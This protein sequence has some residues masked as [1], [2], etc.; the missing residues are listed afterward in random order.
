MKKLFLLGLCA[1]LSLATWASTPPSTPE[2]PF[3][4]D[5]PSIDQ[6]FEGMTALEQWVETCETTYSDL[7]AENNALLQNVKN[8]HQDISA[9]LLGAGGEMDS[10]LKVILIVLGALAV[11]TLGCCLAI[12]IWGS[13]SYY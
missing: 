10:A 5:L 8:D 6:A 11:I 3:Q 2:N 7:A 9:S 12:A 1:L 4:D 13:A